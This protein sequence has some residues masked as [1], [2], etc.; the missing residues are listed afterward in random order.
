MS[1]L[2]RLVM[3]RHGETDGESSIRFHG[4]TD[5]PLSDAGRAHMRDVSG[6][7]RHEVFDL[8]VASTL[9]RSWKGAHIVAGGAPVRLET[10]FREVD[11]GRWEGLTAQ[12]IEESDPVL[13]KEWQENKADFDFPGGE[14]RAEYRER[15]LRGL[16]CIERAA[17]PAVCSSF[18]RARSEPSSSTCSATRFPTVSRRSVA[19]SP[20]PAAPLAI[21]SWAVAAATPKASSDARRRITPTAS[22]HAVRR[23]GELQAAPRA[24]RRFGELQAAPRAARRIGELQAARRAALFVGLLQ[25]REH[26]VVFER[27]GVAHG[28]LARG[29]V[30]QQ[31]PH[32]LARAGLG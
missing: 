22:S 8:V 31:A 19:S 29:D 12:E 21:G 10:N 3:I 18:T 16:D 13:Y 1:Q 28:L 32:D 30:A 14:I 9:Q 11:F 25:L 15:V 26:G 24:A 20:S 4:A 27:R 17:P 5:V 23:F 6:K 2:R 7:L